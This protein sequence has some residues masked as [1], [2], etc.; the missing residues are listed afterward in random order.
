MKHVSKNNFH[1]VSTLVWLLLLAGGIAMAQRRWQGKAV[2]VIGDSISDSTRVGT[3]KCWWSMLCDSTGLQSICYARNGA[4]ILDMQGQV[5]M[6][7]IEQEKRGR[8][9]DLILIF[10]GTND[11]NASLP[12]GEMY[13][14]KKEVTNKDGKQTELLHRAFTTDNATFCGRVNNLLQAIKTHFPQAR[15]LMM[16]PVHRGYAT[17]GSQNVQPDELWAN[18]QGLFL[19]DYIECL[20]VASRAWAVPMLDT[21]IH[22]QLFPI[23]PSY[24]DCIHRTDL[25]RLHPNAKGH[26]HIAL[27]VQGYLE[28]TLP[29]E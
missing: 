3:T 17:F 12:L 9:W 5:E 2:A 15:V 14:V 26:H 25:D 29:L 19:D 4:T 10:G 1:K 13:D 22:T 21:H 11:F 6:A 8:K 24:D 16:S 28:H 27:S 23:S 20:A 7:R 18:T